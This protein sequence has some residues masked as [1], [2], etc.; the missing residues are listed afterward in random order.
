MAQPAMYAVSGC[1]SSFVIA[2]A[3]Q[4]ARLNGI[5]VRSAEQFL[6]N[7]SVPQSLLDQKQ[8]L[9]EALS[10]LQLIGK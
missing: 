1:C 2:N 5:E 10:Q 4:S 3:S 6:L 8:S 7:R 9:F